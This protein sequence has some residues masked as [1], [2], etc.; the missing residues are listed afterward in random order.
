MGFSKMYLFG[1]K[2]VWSELEFGVTRVEE[3][4]DYVIIIRD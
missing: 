2:E 3:I 1:N 4:D